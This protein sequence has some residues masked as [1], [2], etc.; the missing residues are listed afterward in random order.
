MINRHWTWR[1]KI[2]IRTFT[3]VVNIKNV[4]LN[5]SHSLLY[6]EGQAIIF[7]IDSSDRLRMVVAKEELDTLLNHPG[8]CLSVCDICALGSVYIWCLFFGVGKKCCLYYV[9][10]FNLK[11]K[12]FKILEL[13]I[14]LPIAPY[15]F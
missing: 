2:Q 10:I 13:I 9:I 5:F 7:V 12:N 3:W 8:V 14:S 6:R 15:I 1:D 11:F 4:C